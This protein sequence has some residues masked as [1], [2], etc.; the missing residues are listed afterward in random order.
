MRKGRSNEARERTPVVL[1]CPTGNGL[2][3]E[4][5]WCP[6]G[7]K[8]RI[9]RILRFTIYKLQNPKGAL[10]PYVRPAQFAKTQTQRIAAS[11]FLVLRTAGLRAGAKA[12]LR[13]RSRL[14]RARAHGADP[15]RLSHPRLDESR[16]GAGQERE[17]HRAP[18]ER[19]P[20][21]AVDPARRPRQRS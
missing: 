12:A 4:N 8:A 10:Q 11:R 3:G 20:P 1:R 6:L 18:V 17:R 16:Q 2:A 15:G 9:A 13:E 19:V 21:P 5:P 7:K 14:C